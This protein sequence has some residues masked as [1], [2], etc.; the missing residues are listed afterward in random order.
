M[1]RIRRKLDHTIRRAIRVALSSCWNRGMSTETIKLVLNA[2]VGAMAL[3]SRMPERPRATADGSNRL[4]YCIASKRGESVST[5]NSSSMTA[6]L[7][8][9]LGMV[10]ARMGGAEMWPLTNHLALRPSSFHVAPRVGLPQCRLLF[11]SPLTSLIYLDWKLS[12]ALAPM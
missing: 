3:A 7:L 1:L 5:C 8:R 10:R 4:A 9:G 6:A 12:W 2:R 11:L